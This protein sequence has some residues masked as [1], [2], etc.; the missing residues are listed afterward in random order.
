MF[1]IMCFNFQKKA[2]NPEY[3][4]QQN[5]PNWSETTNHSTNRLK[6][7]RTIKPL[8]QK[9]S[10]GIQNDEKGK[11]A[12]NNKSCQNSSFKK[13]KQE[14]IQRCKFTKITIIVIHFLMVI[15]NITV[16]NDPIKSHRLSDW[17]KAGYITGDMVQLEI[18]CLPLISVTKNC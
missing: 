3:Y 11:S 9:I 1:E 5:C 7:S 18:E 8:L 14:N 6:K 13:E 15:L 17:I 12:G 16:V 10:E 4:A 2:F